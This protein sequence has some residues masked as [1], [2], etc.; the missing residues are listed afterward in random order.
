[1]A[2]KN[3]FRREKNGCHIILIYGEEAFLENEDAEG[4]PGWKSTE[5]KEG[6]VCEKGNQERFFDPPR[7]DEGVETERQRYDDNLCADTVGDAD[8]G[9]IAEQRNEAFEKADKS[10][11]FVETPEM[12]AL[13]DERIDE[14][15]G[16]DDKKA[17]KED[18][19]RLSE[20]PAAREAD[21]ENQNEK[22]AQEKKERMGE[23]E[24]KIEESMFA[25]QAQRILDEEAS[26]NER[27]KSRHERCERE[28]SVFDRFGD[29]EK[30]AFHM[31]LFYHICLGNGG[32]SGI[33]IN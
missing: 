10:I 7:F 9:R 23:F 13:K 29:P 22:R 21:E 3:I 31:T 28:R 27:K 20:A 5:D 2:R 17:E 19:R 4:K 11:E 32:S 30:K 14:R 16:Q 6:S 1:M 18:I 25:E 26:E 15:R 24:E 12:T 8:I 33:V